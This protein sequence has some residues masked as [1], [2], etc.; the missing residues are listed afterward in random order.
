MAEVAKLVQ[1]HLPVVPTC[2]RH[3]ITNAGLGA[4]NATIPRANKIARGPRSPAHFKTPI[5]FDRAG[6]DPYPHESRWSFHLID[7]ESCAE[8]PLAA[9]SE[10]PVAGDR[11][12][13]R[14]GGCG[15][16]QQEQGQRV[17]AESVKQDTREEGPKAGTGAIRDILQTQEETESRAR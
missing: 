3:P 5:Y 11:D 16:S 2:L 17:R 14:G 13:D 9:G 6:L 10:K 8:L 7:T 15:N 4:V 12:N 1:R